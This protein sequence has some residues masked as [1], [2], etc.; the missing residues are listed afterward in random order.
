LQAE[1][2]LLL[3]RMN[4][5]T[6]YEIRRAEREG[7]RYEF[8]SIPD[9]DWK[10]QFLQFLCSFEKSRGLK[11]A[12]RAWIS[13]L[14][15]QELLDLSRICSPTT[16]RPLVWHAHIR[17]GNTVRLTHS[18]SLFRTQC[19]KEFAYFGRANRVHHWRDMLRFREEGVAIY[20][21]GGWYS[22]TEDRG[23]LG[24]NR[25]KGA[26]GGRIDREYNADLALTWKGD[27]ALRAR[28]LATAIAADRFLGAA[29]WPHAL[30]QE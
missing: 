19:R 20:D 10:G 2:T 11:T 30:D 27:M 28:S 16:G 9:Q 24:I 4:R 17:A 18:A 23:L 21:F 8:A 13:A 15:D 26:F 25:F 14:F 7:L 1:P 5:T 3:G 6:R 12:D 22:G 29:A